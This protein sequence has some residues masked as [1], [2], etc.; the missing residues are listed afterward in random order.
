MCKGEKGQPHIVL[1]VL[2]D[3]GYHDMGDFTAPHPN[4]CKAPVV[5]ALMD[6]GVKLK[7]FYIMLLCSQTRAA[8]MTG[9]HPIC[10]G[11]QTGVASGT[12][13]ARNWILEGEPMLAERMKAAG[14]RTKMVGK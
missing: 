13:G 8:L 12:A 4:R 11:A 9:R 14:Y 6:N 7:N 3:L 2:D 10:Y 5:S 1:A